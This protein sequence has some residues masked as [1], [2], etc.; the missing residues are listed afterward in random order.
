MTSLGRTRSASAKSRAGLTE[1]MDVEDVNSDASSDRLDSELQG[2]SKFLG[3]AFE[4]ISKQEREETEGAAGGGG[5]SSA[6]KE[7]E[8]DSKLPKEKT[9]KI[10]KER[11]F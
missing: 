8:G 5:N 11:A 2:A 6:T 9:R 10:R 7:K 4:E 1:D 3:S